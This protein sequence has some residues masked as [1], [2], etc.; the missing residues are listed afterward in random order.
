M[1]VL[2][3]S[4][5]DRPVRPIERRCRSAASAST[6]LKLTCQSLCIWGHRVHRLGERFY[7]LIEAVIQT[8]DKGILRTAREFVRGLC[9]DELGPERLDNL[10]KLY[11]PPRLADGANRSIK[12]HGIRPKLPRLL[13]AQLEK[14]SPPSE[15]KVTMR[16][17]LESAKKK[18][19]HGRNYVFDCFWWN[20]NVPFKERDKVIQ[21]TEENSHLSLVAPPAD[22]IHLAKWRRG[23]RRIT[24]AYYEHPKM[25]RL[26]L[27]K[28]ARR[29]GYGAKKRLQCDGLVRNKE[30]AEKLLA[31]F[32]G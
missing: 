19:K 6:P 15:T 24:F 7:A 14:K 2:R 28:L 26:R 12:T 30:F 25:R 29:I 5:T 9:L 18:R 10:A 3:Q 31:A 20:G 8:T 1:R 13:L 16:E 21:I 4:R 27:E 11:R 22:I 17:G 23:N 32:G